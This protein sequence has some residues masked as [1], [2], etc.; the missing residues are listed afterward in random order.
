VKLWPTSGKGSG[1]EWVFTLSDLD[2]PM[3]LSAEDLRTK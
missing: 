3:E 1:D 2:Q